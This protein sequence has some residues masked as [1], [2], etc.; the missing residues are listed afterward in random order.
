MNTIWL[1]KSTLLIT[2]LYLKEFVVN[3]L[4]KA[5]FSVGVALNGKCLHL[6]LLQKKKNEIIMK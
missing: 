5:G 3:K 6:I 1:E 4:K 2:M